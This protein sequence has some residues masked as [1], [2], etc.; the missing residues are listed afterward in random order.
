[1]ETSILDK[2]NAGL[3]PS[4]TNATTAA[5]RQ[6]NAQ[7]SPLTKI[8][9]GYDRELEQTP[10]DDYEEMYLLDKENPEE[11]LKDKS[12]LKDAWTTFMNSRDQ[13]NL[14]SERAKLAKDI[15]PVL[16][17]IDYELNFLSDKQKLKNLENT[18]PTLDENS[19][20]YKNAISEYFQLQRTLADR[21]E[22][23]DSILSKYGEKEGDNIDARIE[24]L[25]NSRKS[26]EEERSKVNEEIN[27]IYSNLRE[28]SENYTPSSEFRIKEQRA[29]DKPWYSPDYFLYAGP[30]L[31]GSSMATV[32][33][34]IA[35]ALATGALWLGRHYA[36]TGALNAVPGIGAASN[37]IG[38]G[39][40]IAAT[41]ASVAGNIYSRHRES[42]AQ[43]YG[44][45]RS[46][47]EDSLKEQGIDIKQYAE[48]GRNQL[49]QQDPNID[50]SKISDDEII[51]RVISG[52]ITINDATL[53]NAKRSLKDG[54]ERVY[55]N[56]MALSAMDV[57]QSA[58]V[59]APLGKAMG[60]I[61]TAPI[62]TA[63]N[64]LLKTG[65]KLSEAAASKYNKLIDAY[66]GFNARLAY[67]SPVKNASLQAAKALGRLG[68]SAT[69]EAF[70]EANQDVFDYDYISGK[71]DGKSSSIFQSLMGLANANYRTAK[72]LSGIDT[73]SELA[74]DPQFW[75][76][77]KGGF[78][79]GLYMGGPTIAY[80]SGLK[81]YKDMTANSFVRDVVADHIGKKDAMIKAM[82]YS[83][84]ANKKLNYQQNVLD[85]LENYKY[86]LPEGIT[87]QDLNDEI[88]TANNIFSLSKSKV[89]QNIGKTI[90][91]NPGTT[92]Y[93]TLIG[94]QHLATIDAQEALDNANQ[95]QEADNNFYTTLENDQMLNHYS[96]EEKLT[97]VALTKLNIQ[98]QAL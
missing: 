19:E 35:D 91:Y 41:A 22:Q 48:I 95:A 93:N 10:I 9:T 63:L 29:Q 47:I 17:D 84:M 45:Y 13:I 86:N 7:H 96:P 46:R 74:N 64:P 24:Y 26:W 4:K 59:F 73:E 97:A 50:V 27:N 90:G 69:G 53:V 89:N 98:K 36:T 15:N 38:W 2:Y 3:I 67:N 87:E 1:M 88:A 33:G 54:L 40:A 58:L 39:S 66:T 23:Y 62:K 61:I 82:S 8:K 77:V 12:Y 76:D 14:M 30:G 42:L 83:E 44:A 92:E 32:N 72:I 11:T 31:T 56:N 20:E 49:K 43:V 80:H 70:E 52:E 85:V 25:S 5:I 71:Y 68:F 6:V 75:N 16:D 28:R 94:L 79:L 55:D 21:Q 37:L 34:Y 60:K 51:D 81:T 65:T 57:A 18:I 78:A